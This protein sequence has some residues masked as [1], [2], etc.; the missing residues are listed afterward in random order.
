M[1]QS[2]ECT[3]SSKDA[4]DAAAVFALEHFQKRMEEEIIANNQISQQSFEISQGSTQSIEKQNLKTD[5]INEIKNGNHSRGI[6]VNL[7]PRISSKINL[8]IGTI[9]GLPLVKVVDEFRRQYRAISVYT[10]EQ[11]VQNIKILNS[12]QSPSGTWVAEIFV[13]ETTFKSE[14]VVVMVHCATHDAHLSYPR[15][16]V[17]LSLFGKLITDR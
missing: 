16:F 17:L 14:N 10:F 1:F 5:L 9:C 3:S 6:T 2:D 11:L 12:K 8:N 7:S 15:P 4:I 13:R